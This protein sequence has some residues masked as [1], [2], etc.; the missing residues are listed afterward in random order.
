[1]G[2][3]C[4]LALKPWPPR[5]TFVT[6]L[7]V[8]SWEHDIGIS[9]LLY[10]LALYSNMAIQTFTHQRLGQMNMRQINKLLVVNALLTA[11]VLVGCQGEDAITKCVK[12][13]IQADIDSDKL[14]KTDT[15]AMTQAESK[16]RASCM[17]S[18]EQKAY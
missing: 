17:E 2:F 6:T 12:A 5:I 14:T 4:P 16:F 1:M 3:A 8:L 13:N 9:I 18:M 15:V 11:I 10:V 7:K